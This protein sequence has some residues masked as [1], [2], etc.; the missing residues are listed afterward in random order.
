MVRVAGF[1]PT[2][3]WTRTKRDT[4]LRH[5]RIESV[6][7]TSINAVYYY[8]VFPIGCQENNFLTSAIL[9]QPKYF[10]IPT[11]KPAYTYSDTL[12]KGRAP[13]WR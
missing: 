3:S 1:E 12:Q 13:V 10:C 5:T 9:F 11:N 7:S 8:N 6:Y 4:K 2:A